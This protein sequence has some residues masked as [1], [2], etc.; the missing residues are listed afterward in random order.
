MP[1]EISGRGSS[2]FQRARFLRNGCPEFVREKYREL[3]AERFRGRR[4]EPVEAGDPLVGRGQD[5]R[6]RPQKLSSRT[7]QRTLWTKYVW[8]LFISIIKQ[9]NYFVERLSQPI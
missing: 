8:T 5:D 4:E 3:R 1:I 2:T 9:A 7:H 6:D